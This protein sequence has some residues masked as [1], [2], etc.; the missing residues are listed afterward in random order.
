MQRQSEHRQSDG[1]VARDGYDGDLEL[2]VAPW[3]VRPRVSWACPTCTFLNKRHDATACEM[4]DA[5]RPF[6]GVVAA[7]GVRVDGFATCSVRMGGARTISGSV[8]C[9]GSASC[10]PA[11]EEKEHVDV[12][13]A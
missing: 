9:D 2:R 10:A 13:A 6:P 3:N 8:P 11:T 12:A 7:I 5:P 1:D 4:C